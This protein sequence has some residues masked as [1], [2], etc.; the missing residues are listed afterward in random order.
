VPRHDPHDLIA[1]A[2]EPF[3]AWADVVGALR[4]TV[5]ADRIATLAT[6]VAGLLGASAED[7]PVAIDRP[8]APAFDPAIQAFVDQFVLD[9]SAISDDQRADALTRFGADA[10]PFEQALH[11][12]DLGTRTGAAWRQL[13][14]VRFTPGGAGGVDLWTALETFVRGVARLRL[15]SCPQGS[16][17]PEWTA[18]ATTG[19][20]ALAVTGGRLY[21]A[22][23]D[24]FVHVYSL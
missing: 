17:Q 20:H 18:N 7:V 21:A 13:F 8:H 2:P 15:A 16:C 11:T 1:L 6:S 24:G 4:A 22:E 12:L 9:V 10:F 5:G 14:G 23:D 19:V 3:A